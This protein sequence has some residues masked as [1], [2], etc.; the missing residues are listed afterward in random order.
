MHEPQ[1]RKFCSCIKKVQKSLKN[2]KESRAI[3]I[4]VKSVLQ[5]R[6]RTLKTFR[7]R[8]KSPR[9]ITQSI[10]AKKSGRKANRK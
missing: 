1:T 4:C 6:G 10:K 3:A 2:S 8:G 7:C 9:V 5:T